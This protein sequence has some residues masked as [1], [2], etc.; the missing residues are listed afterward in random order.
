MLATHFQLIPRLR[1]LRFY[2]YYPIRVHVVVL[3]HSGNFMFL[4][5]AFLKIPSDCL[6]G[7]WRRLNNKELQKFYA[8]PYIIKVVKWMSGTCITWDRS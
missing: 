4:H 1:I 6:A 5:Y 3:R 2:L 7:G 8:L